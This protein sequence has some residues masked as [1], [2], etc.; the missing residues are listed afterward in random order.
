MERWE[1]GNSISPALYILN[2]KRY[3]LEFLWEVL[4]PSENCLLNVYCV[5]DLLLVSVTT[6]MFHLAF[7]T[8][9]LFCLAHSVP[10]CVL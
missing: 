1:G 3:G 8:C 9:C 2:L 7:G 4:G 6:E 5:G 10:A